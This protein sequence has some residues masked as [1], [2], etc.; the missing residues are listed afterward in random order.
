LENNFEGVS[1]REI[2]QQVCAVARLEVDSSLTV[3]VEELL[4]LV[5]FLS[6]S[7]CNNLAESKLHPMANSDGKASTSERVVRSKHLC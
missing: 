5:Y 4:L 3:R 2:A 7:I 1:L 6:Y